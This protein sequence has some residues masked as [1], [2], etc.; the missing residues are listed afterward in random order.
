MPA[1]RDYYEILGVPR[2]ADEEAIRRAY[3][4]LARM[5]HPDVSSDPDAEERFKEVG[6]AF[7]VLKDPEKRELY[8]RFGADWRHAQ[9]AG[10]P[11]P[12]PPGADRTAPPPE[13]ED[14]FAQMFG[15]DRGEGA[16]F[17]VRG[18]DVE[19]VLDVT[20]EEA[21]GGGSR[22]ITLPDG[23]SL[24]VTIPKGLVDGRRIRLAGQGGEGLGGGPK[25]DLFL[26]ARILPHATFEHD[27]R[28]LH[29]ELPVSPWEAALG[30][31]V[32]VHTLTGTV[33]VTVPKGSSGG[34]RLRLKGRG[35]PDPKGADGDLY[36]TLR[37]VVP[38]KLGDREKELF[39]ALAEESSF[40]PS[41]GG[42]VGT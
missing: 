6:E 5:H 1:D 39:E 18:N 27:G 26:S 24:D 17:R 20:L 21:A 4:K 37:I 31:K 10:A 28:D 40:T 34:R 25:G 15:G 42:R 33:S 9:A 12:P 23:T 13:Y 14:L 30:A 7:D 41:G 3:R 38:R 16:A 35:I 11:P 19:A 32:G 36:A 29:M 2:G 8:D 22:R